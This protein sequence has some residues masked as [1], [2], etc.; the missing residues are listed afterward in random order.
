[1]ELQNFVIDVIESMDGVVELLEYALCYVMIPN[2][3]SN[4]FNG[5]SEMLLAFDFEVAQENPEAEFITFGSYTLEQLITIANEKAVNTIRFV[6]V[7]G[8]SLSKAEDKI[9]KFLGMD[10]SQLEIVKE[11]EIMGTWILFNYK[12][13]YTSHERT[14][15]IKDVW[16]NLQNGEVDLN[17]QENKSL[18]FHEKSLIKNY[19][20]PPQHSILNAFEAS[21]LYVKNQTEEYSNLIVNKVEF[22]KELQRIDEYYTELEAETFKKLERKGITDKRKAELISKGEALKLEKIKQQK[23]ME[24][25]YTVDVD[26]SLDN[27]IMY[28]IPL[29]EYQVKLKFRGSEEK[30]I[31]HYNPVIKTFYTKRNYS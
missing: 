29:I 1:M 23:E 17:I 24:N 13:G 6:L 18:L 7:D 21:Y 8:L 15:D 3:Y 9:K 12:I 19:P 5:K 2:E 14:E 20:I 16:V 25:K 10:K 28:F 30:K 22:S 26:L 31:I 4:Y 11:K 27:T